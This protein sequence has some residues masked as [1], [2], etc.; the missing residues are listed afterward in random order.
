MRTPSNGTLLT[1]IVGSA[2]ATIM[3]GTVWFSRYLVFTLGLDKD[4][5]VGIYGLSGLALFLIT[6]TWRLRRRE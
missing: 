4:L 6:V 1:V 3:F 2:T 5:V